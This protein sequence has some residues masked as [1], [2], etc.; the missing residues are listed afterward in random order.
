MKTDAIFYKLFQIAPRTFFELLQITPA[1]PYRFESLTF[2]TTEKRIDGLLEPAE[3]GHPLYFIEVQAF[4]DRAI[5]WRT[6]RQ[7]STFFEQR[8]QHKNEWQAVV[9]WLNKNDDPGFGTVPIWDEDSSQRLFSVDL[10]ASLKSLDEAS[11]ALNV[12]R[13]LIV[14]TE[15]EVRQNLF[16]W[17]ENIKS[18]PELNSE[19][20]QRLITVLTQLIEQ[21][22]KTLTYKELSEMLQLTPFKETISYKEALQEDLREDRVKRLTGMIKAKFKF[23]DTTM[24]KLDL[25]LRQLSMEDLKSLFEDIFDMNTLK[26][27]NA[28][29][30]A[31][32]PETENS[33]EHG[34]DG[35]ALAPS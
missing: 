18:T 17:V 14:D 8:S 19:S 27:L 22:I 23:A 11:L 31:R 15:I 30:D 26:E 9:L 34:V 29:I 35:D 21:K 28:W 16:K 10:S 4:S 7:V 2:K 13:P 6:S 20:E 12:L 3:E 5:Y 25:R 33:N 1:C 24:A 32:L